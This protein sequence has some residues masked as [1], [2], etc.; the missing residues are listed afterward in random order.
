[1]ESKIRRVV[2]LHLP[3]DTSPTLVSR[4]TDVHISNISEDYNMNNFNKLHKNTMTY[5]CNLLMFR[6]KSISKLTRE[7][8]YTFNCFNSL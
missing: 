6:Y 5:K 7:A 3:R 4:A 8:E 1:M 2:C